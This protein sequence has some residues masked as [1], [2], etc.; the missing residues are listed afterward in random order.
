MDEC[1]ATCRVV[2]A[3]CPTI[4]V[5]RPMDESIAVCHVVSPTGLA[6]AIRRLGQESVSTCHVISALYPVRRPVDESI[7][8]CG[9]VSTARSTIAVRQPGNRSPSRSGAWSTV[10]E[11]PIGHRCALRIVVLMIEQHGLGQPA[12]PPGQPAPGRVAEGRHRDP[13][14]ITYRR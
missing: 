11:A 12:Q 9:V 10:R 1:I 14:T 5:R 7:A 8:T 4:A 6:V 13:Q 2:S 3:L